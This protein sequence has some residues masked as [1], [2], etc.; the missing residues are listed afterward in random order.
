[1]NKLGKILI[2]IILAILIVLL[3]DY[4]ILKK[5]NVDE[6]PNIQTSGDIEEKEPY[7]ERIKREIIEKVEISGDEKISDILQ[8]DIYGDGLK[9]FID[10]FGDEALAA[11]IYTDHKNIVTIIPVSDFLD[12]EYYYY[13][14]EK[15]VAYIREF[16]GIGGRYEYYFKDGELVKIIKNVE[17]E[18]KDVF[19]EESAEKILKAA[20]LVKEKYIK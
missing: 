11:D 4:K 6:K 14:N 9:Y 3:F 1:M 10:N 19:S 2:V 16:I 17:E 5:D 12:N 13:E 20:E 7:E 18:N 15:F 8:L